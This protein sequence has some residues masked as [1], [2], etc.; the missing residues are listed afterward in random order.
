MA[1]LLTP[2]NIR[3]RSDTAGRDEGRA[4]LRAVSIF[5]L[6]LN[7][8][9]EEMLDVLHSNCD[10]DRACPKSHPTIAGACHVDADNVRTN[11][12]TR[13]HTH[14]CI[15]NLLVTH[16]KPRTESRESAVDPPESYMEDKSSDKS[17]LENARRGRCRPAGIS[18]PG[19][20]GRDVATRARL[21][22]A[23]SL[24]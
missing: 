23:S 19:R 22:S 1:I 13:K 12:L 20:T 24:L 14:T 15:A 10:G 3:Q 17:T 9:V 6:G 2:S 16:I 11:E 4:V 21:G 8:K 5:D 18:P 7:P